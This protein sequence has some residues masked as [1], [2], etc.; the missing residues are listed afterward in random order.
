MRDIMRLKQ[1]VMF[2]PHEWFNSF[3]VLNQCN[4]PNLRQDQVDTLVW[5]YDGECYDFSVK[6]AW[7]ATRD[8]GEEVNWAYLVWSKYTIPRHTTHLWLV[9]RR[10][11]LTQDRMRQ[12]HVGNEVD[13]ALLRCPLCKGQQDSHEHLF[14]ECPFS[15]QV[16]N[17]V[18]DVA[19]MRGI[20][21]KWSDIVAW[22]LPISKQNK[23]TTIVAGGSC[24]LFCVA[25]TKQ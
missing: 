25:R 16:W 6:H 19:G 9:M 2:W 22:L 13:L 11:L 1:W 17:L 12:W 10:R 8:R 7:N 21:S 15:V 3:P 5:K 4:V 18:M 20:S 23:V 14:F 24:F